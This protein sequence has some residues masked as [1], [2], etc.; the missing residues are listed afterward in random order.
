MKLSFVITVYN[1]Q[2]YIGQ[3][4][5]SVVSISMPEK[6][7]EIIVVDDGS[8]DQSWR[9]LSDYNNKFSNI[10]IF[11]QENRG[12]GSARNLGISKA[13]G[14]YLWFVDGDDLLIPDKVAE[15]VNFAFVNEADVVLFDYLP[16]NEKGEFEN[17]ISFKSNF[18]KTAYLCGPEY[19]LLNYRH[20]YLWVHFFKR[21]IFMENGLLFHPDIKMQ[22]GEILP[23]ILNQTNRVA[24]FREKLINYRYR[25]NSA[26][27]NQDEAARAHFYH[28]IVTVKLQLKDFMDTINPH[29]VMYKGVALKHIQL[30]QMLFTNLINNNYSEATNQK[31]VYL[32]KQH[33][34]LPLKK[35][36]GF[37]YLMNL[38]FNILRIIL[39]L[40]PYFGRKVYQKFFS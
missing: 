38:K 25:P 22:D 39:N 20:S 5:D 16:I 9:I 21:S 29:S 10:K 18:G 23:K 36:T 11:S 33:K 8:T 27:N 1:L 31:F 35:I 12:V 24:Y 14:A 17:W 4:L 37:T 6:D 40:N 15:A 32:L 13:L 19:Y 28:S 3:C 26:V 30:N 2:E 7:Y 34:L